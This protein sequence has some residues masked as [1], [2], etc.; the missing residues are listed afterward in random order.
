MRNHLVDNRR[1]LGGL[2]VRP[3]AIRITSH[4]PQGGTDVSIHQFRINQQRRSEDSVGISQG[5]RIWLNVQTSR[6]D[7]ESCKLNRTLKVH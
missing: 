1:N 7:Y 2:D 6:V 3:P 4:Q 5:V